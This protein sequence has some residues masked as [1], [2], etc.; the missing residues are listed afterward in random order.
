MKV[1][2]LLLLCFFAISA[3]ATRADPLVINSGYFQVRSSEGLLTFSVQGDGFSF[4]GGGINGIVPGCQD[5]SLG[6]MTQ[7]NYRVSGVDSIG[8][9]IGG[10]SYHDHD[11]PGIGT[12]FTIT[13][14]AYTLAQTVAVPFTFTGSVSVSDHGTNFSYDFVGQGIATVEYF[15]VPDGRGGTLFSFTSATYTFTSTPE[16]AALLLLGTGLAGVRFAARRKR[17][18]RKK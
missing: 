4:G 9:L 7:A 18:T 10:T 12:L 3:A 14:P 8:I 5:C 15:V 2:L 6:T 17:A 16:P 11:P 13:T 1:K